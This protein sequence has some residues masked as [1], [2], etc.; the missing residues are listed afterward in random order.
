MGSTPAA[1]EV[2][3]ALSWPRRPS[4]KGESYYDAVSSTLMAWGWHEPL[5]WRWGCPRYAWISLEAW[6]ASV[7]HVLALR[8]VSLVGPVDVLPRRY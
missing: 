5:E 8:D 2:S 6:R 7:L 1:E 4:E 3:A